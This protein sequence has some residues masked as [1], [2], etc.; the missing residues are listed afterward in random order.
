[1]AANSPILLHTQPG[2]WLEI[3]YQGIYKSFREGEE[4]SI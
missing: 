1:M 3:V 2:I 4:M